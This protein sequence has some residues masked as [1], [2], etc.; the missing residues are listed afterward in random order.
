MT[1]SKGKLYVAFLWLA[2]VFMIACLTSCAGQPETVYVPTEV[3]KPVPVSC[4]PPVVARP[5]DLLMALPYV[6]TLSQGMKACLAQH[7]YDIG[8]QGQLE[9]SVASCNE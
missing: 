3:D 9:A 5:P 8:Y 6:A 7:D 1:K 4:K 2:G